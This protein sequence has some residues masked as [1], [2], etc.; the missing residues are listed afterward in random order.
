VQVRVEPFAAR[1]I[2]VLVNGRWKAAVGINSR[3]LDG[4]TRRELAI[5][6]R[7][8]AKRS[9]TAAKRDREAYKG[10]GFNDYPPEAYDSRLAAQQSEEKYLLNS[11]KLLGA[12]KPEIAET[13]DDR[14][15]EFTRAPSAYGFHL[16]KAE[17][18]TRFSDSPAPVEHRDSTPLEQFDAEEGSS[19]EVS[20]PRNIHQS[21][22]GVLIGD[23][24]EEFL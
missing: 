20:G 18:F 9:N 15:F 7:E 5:V 4:R 1:V 24:L 21:Q 3:Q 12:L 22:E 13:G 19:V 6:A 8:H 2:Y 14:E 16:G 17:V 10:E 11:N 23:A